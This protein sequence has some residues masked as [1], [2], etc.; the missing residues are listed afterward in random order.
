MR[1]VAKIPGLAINVD[2][3]YL[4][5]YFFFH[6]EVKRLLLPAAEN[7]LKKLIYYN[8]QPT[9]KEVIHRFMY[10]CSEDYKSFCSSLN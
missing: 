9:Y 6:S 5:L 7:C 2:E 3:I 4:F 1:P 10:C 8:P